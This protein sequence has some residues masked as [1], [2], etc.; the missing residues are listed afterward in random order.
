MCVNAT[1]EQCTIGKTWEWVCDQIGGECLEGGSVCRD[2]RSGA[3]GA[4]PGDLQRILDATARGGDEVAR[5][6][7][8]LFERYTRTVAAEP[9]AHAMDY[10]H[11][12]LHLVKLS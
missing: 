11:A 4:C 12:Y 3:I 10:V 2:V 8:E 6:V 7:D 9:E 1:D 5:I